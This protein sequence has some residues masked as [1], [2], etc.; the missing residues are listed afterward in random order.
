MRKLVASGGVKKKRKKKNPD[1]STCNRSN[2]KQTGKKKKT[3]GKNGKVGKHAHT[4]DISNVLSGQGAESAVCYMMPW[5]R[6]LG[7]YPAD[8]RHTQKVQSH[9][10]TIFPTQCHQKRE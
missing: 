9:D 7:Q 4:A 10:V 3:R 1:M 5:R 2:Q 8:A 6:C